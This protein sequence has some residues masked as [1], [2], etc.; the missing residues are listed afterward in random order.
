MNTQIRYYKNV[1]NALRKKL[2]NAEAKALLSKAVHLISIGANDY[3]ARFVSNYSLFLPYS[4]QQ[5]IDIV[6][7]NLTT[8]IKVCSNS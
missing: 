5:F 4:Q 7:G 8:A 3:G 6:I 1:S 2:G